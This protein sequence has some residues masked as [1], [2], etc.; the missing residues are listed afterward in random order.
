MLAEATGLPLATVVMTQVIGYATPLMPY[1][2][3]PIVVA[4]GMAGVPAR[5]GLRLCLAVA[6]ATLLVLA[7]LDYAWFRLLGW[8][9][10]ATP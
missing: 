8:L 2:A 4:M 3:A 7:P 10:P 6:A 9:G 5:D 1:Q